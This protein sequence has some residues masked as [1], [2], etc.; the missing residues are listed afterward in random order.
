M[1][2]VMEVQGHVT[3]AMAF[4]DY[5]RGFVD[6]R[7]RSTRTGYWTMQLFLFV[8]YFILMLGLVLAFSQVILNQNDNA[9]ANAAGKTVGTLVIVMTVSA[10]V[11]LLPSLALAFRRYR[12]AGMRGRGMLVIWV[13]VVGLQLVLSLRKL[14]IL[15]SMPTRYWGG[16][17]QYMRGSM[18][19]WPLWLL[20]IFC[21]VIS[22]FP[23]DFIAIKPDSSALMKFFLRVRAMPADISGNDQSSID[24]HDA[25]T[26]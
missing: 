20:G 1:R 11:L 4:K 6:F 10:V 13:A 17:L 26:K 9:S 22:L 5:W 25:T 2:K 15:F 8:W 18:P 24:H 7:G 12:D 23:A 3:F 21:F 19:L 14:W 16:Y